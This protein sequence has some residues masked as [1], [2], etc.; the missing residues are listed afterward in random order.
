MKGI[1]ELWK[2]EK[3]KILYYI[4][5][6]YQIPAT[7]KKLLAMG[8]LLCLAIIPVVYLLPLKHYIWLLKTKPKMPLAIDDRKYYIRLARTTM[9]RIERFSP[10]R[11]SCLVKSATLKML[12]NSLGIESSIALGVNNSQPHLLRAHA[13][14]KVDD[15]VVYLMRKRFYEVYS[16]G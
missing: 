8:F 13:F 6:F 5:R 12:L 7:E 15:K 1:K 14:V 2:K 3:M 9:R 4:K 11:F 10:V 16:V